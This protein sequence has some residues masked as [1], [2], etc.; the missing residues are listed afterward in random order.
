MFQRPYLEPEVAYWWF[1]VGNASKS[2]EFSVVQWAHDGAADDA[3]VRQ[4]HLT[5]SAKLRFHAVTDL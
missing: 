1:G 4:F 2:V 3:I 5:I